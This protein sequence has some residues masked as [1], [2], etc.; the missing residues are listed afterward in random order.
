MWMWRL[1]VETYCQT[2]I[3][4]AQARLVFLRELSEVDPCEAGIDGHG[5]MAFQTMAPSQRI[6]RTS[7]RGGTN[8][9]GV[10]I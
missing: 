6:C 9:W 3:C 1:L 10:S 4:E 7:S 5:V 2:V 8:Q